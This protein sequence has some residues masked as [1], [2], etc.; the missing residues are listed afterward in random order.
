MSL[1]LIFTFRGVFSM[2]LKADEFDQNA[3]GAGV[4]VNKDK[5]EEAYNFVFNK[6]VVHLQ[7]LPVAPGEAK[8]KE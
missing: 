4:S 2:F 6:E 8:K 1:L 7:Q 5:L 3:V